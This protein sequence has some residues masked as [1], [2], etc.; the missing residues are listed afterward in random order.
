[1]TKTVCDICGSENIKFHCTL[2]IL[3]KYYIKGV[4]DVIL[5]K[6]YN[7]ELKKMD[8]CEKDAI[9]IAQFIKTLKYDEK[10]KK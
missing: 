4:G 3:E 9:L 2:P 6:Y 10:N 5:G 8:L 1:M 7:L